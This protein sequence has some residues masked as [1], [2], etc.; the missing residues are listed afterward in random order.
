MIMETEVI[1]RRPIFGKEIRQKSKSGFFSASDLMIAG[2]A[3]RSSQGMS[4][5]YLNQWF[6]RDATK[7]F[8]TALNEEI[9]QP[10]KVSSRGKTGEIWVHPFLFID[11]ALAISPQLKIETYKWLYDELLKY[12]NDSGDSYK[13]MCGSLWVNTVN[14]SEF[15]AYIKDV[16]LKIKKSLGVEEWN[17][18]SVETL[19]MRDK[20]HD[21]IA[22]L[23]DVIRHNDNS[24]RLG[25]IKTIDQLKNKKEIS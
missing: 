21:N 25:I 8:M 9:G 20:M 22:I 17:D 18:A 15:P 7:E 5:F 6:Q 19:R 3:W 23:A 16:A 4:L 13:R 14:K 10:C 12:R 2:N 11:I 24:V 1:V